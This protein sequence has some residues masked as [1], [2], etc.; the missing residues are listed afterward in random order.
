MK[1]SWGRVFARM[2]LLAAGLAALSVAQAASPP[3]LRLDYA[4]YS[5]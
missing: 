5:P 2:T 4:Y 3:E 1:W